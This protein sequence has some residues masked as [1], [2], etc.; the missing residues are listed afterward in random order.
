A[1]TLNGNAITLGG[2]SDA[3]TIIAN[4]GALK[5]VINF[6]VRT[7]GAGKQTIQVNSNASLT[8]SGHVMDAGTSAAPL[9]KAGAGTLTLSNH[10]AT[11]PNSFSGKITVSGGILAIT[12]ANALG[13]TTGDTTVQPGAELQFAGINGTVAESLL[14]NGASGTV[15]GSLHQTSGTTTLSGNV[16]L[17]TT[18]STLQ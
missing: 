2:A 8:I 17:A 16:Q 14:L 13:N 4:A 15:K 12:N 11:A 3:N 1:Y 9:V 6:D 7:T 10:N 5:D 18:D